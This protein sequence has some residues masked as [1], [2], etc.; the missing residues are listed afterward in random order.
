MSPKLNLAEE[1]HD[2]LDSPTWYAIVDMMKHDA[3]TRR[4]SLLTS[5]SITESQRYGCVYALST[6][7]QLCDRIYE[8]VGRKMPP[9]LRELF[10]GDP[11]EN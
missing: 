4:R 5:T 1:F 2:F 8:V 11:K 6:Y 3:T 10:T 7:K 9:E